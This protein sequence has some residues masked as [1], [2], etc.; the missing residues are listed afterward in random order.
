M[1]LCS[2]CSA[3]ISTSSWD[4][5]YRIFVLRHIPLDKIFWGKIDLA[6]ASVNPSN[7]RVG[8]YYLIKSSSSLHFYVLC[9]SIKSKK[10]YIAR[11]YLYSWVFNSWYGVLVVYF[12]YCLG[13]LYVMGAQ[14][15]LFLALLDYVSTAHEIEILQFVHPSDPRP[16]VSKLSML[17]MRWFQWKRKYQNATHPTNRSQKFSNFSWIFSMVLTELLFL[18]WV[19]RF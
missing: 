4:E 10:K 8:A 12:L 16:Y 15:P 17:P 13:A 2:L 3:T 7:G 1:L 6:Y 14:C 19:S 11:V 9:N 18:F 5:S